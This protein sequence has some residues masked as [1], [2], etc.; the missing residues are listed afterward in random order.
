[1]RSIRSFT[2][3]RFVVSSQARRPYLGLKD[4][5]ATLFKAETR[6]LKESNQVESASEKP[7]LDQDRAKM[8]FDMPKW[9]WPAWHL[10]PWKPQKWGFGK[11]VK[12]GAL[13][14]PGCPGCALYADPSFDCVKDP[15]E[16]H[17]GI[18]C[19]N[20][21]GASTD[22]MMTKKSK[23]P[24]S[25]AGVKVAGVAAGDTTL[26]IYAQVGRI[27]EI[28]IGS[29]ASIGPSASVWVDPQVPQHTICGRMVDGAGSVCIACTDVT[30]AVCNCASPPS[31][32]S[33]VSYD[34]TITPGGTAYVTVTGGCGPYTFTVAG[35]GYTVVGSGATGT[36]TSANGTCGVNYGVYVTVTVKDV[37]ET[38]KTCVIRNT[39]GAWV[40]DCREDHPEDGC[41]GTSNVVTEYPPGIYKYV[42]ICA[43]VCEHIPLCGYLTT[44]C[45]P[46]R[47][48]R[49]VIRYIWTCL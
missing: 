26:E 45:L 46:G 33:I 11:G 36:V 4:S 3:W 42:T 30:C 7:Y 41:Y 18:W 39:G 16:I 2:F 19:T 17:A 8:H 24:G 49:E 6:Y 15:V 43:Y 35:T 47:G 12:G 5:I 13:P 21:P 10:N 20:T 48:Q 14:I 29:W 37:C 34:S 44:L 27:K 38:E 31:P 25:T 9:D 22:R 28:S 32:F 40:E 1:L 23:G